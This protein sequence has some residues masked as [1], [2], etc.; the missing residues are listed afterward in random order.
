MTRVAPWTFR[1]LS[2]C[3]SLDLDPVS[4]RLPHS[5]THRLPCA[6]QP[7]SRS[8]RRHRLTGWPAVGLPLR[9]GSS[10]LWWLW[11]LSHFFALSPLLGFFFTHSYGIGALHGLGEASKQA[12]KQARTHASKARLA[13]G[14]FLA[15]TPALLSLLSSC[16]WISW[17]VGVALFGFSV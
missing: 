1:G 15:F 11:L 3:A 7:G 5:H 12:S 14:I 10:L 4:D 8:V 17:W 13:G 9:F 16:S 2:R 6:S